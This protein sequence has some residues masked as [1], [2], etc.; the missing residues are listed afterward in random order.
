MK[1]QI[2]YFLMLIAT[3]SAAQTADTMNVRLKSG[4]IVPYAVSSVNAL[5][6]SGVQGKDTLNVKLKSGPTIPY[7]V[8]LLDVISFSNGQSTD[9]LQIMLNGGAVRF[10][11]V[12]SLSGLT[13]IDW[14]KSSST[15]PLDSGGGSS[16][17]LGQNFPNPFFPATTIP[18]YLPESRE[19]TV[20][21]Y[22][23][24]GRLVINLVRQ[25]EGPGFYQV[26][27]D[28][29]ALPEGIYIYKLSAGNSVITRRMTL[30]KQ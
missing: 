18:Y 25:S 14:N 2:F 20:A 16:F 27:W 9:T 8:S 23:L 17:L 28:G 22:T 4:A 26:T 12:S 6:F 7:S 30:L 24:E 19:V 29:S 21:V 11:P 10:Y 1:R 5:T 15:E 3:S 13:F